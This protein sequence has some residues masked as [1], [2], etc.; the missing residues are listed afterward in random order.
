VI[1]LV[2]VL[3]Q[4]KKDQS[5]YSI[6]IILHFAAVFRDSKVL[7]EVRYSFRTIVAR[8]FSHRDVVVRCSDVG[9]MPR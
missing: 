9:M 3:D 8:V 6:Q 5:W 1:I 7:R 4:Q 2:L